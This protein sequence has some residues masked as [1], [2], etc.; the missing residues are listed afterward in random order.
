MNKILLVGGL[1]V[2]AANSH[3]IFVIDPTPGSLA[4]TENVLF[5]EVGLIATGSLVQGVLNDSRALVDFYG[6][7]E[8]L[9]TPPGGQARVTAVDGSFTML[10]TAMTDPGLGIA[11]YQ[12][13]VNAKTN[14]NLTIDLYVGNSIAA[15]G[16]FAISTSGSNWFRI[17]G[18]QG[19]V[20]TKVSM[21][22]TGQISDVRQNRIGAA[23]AP[24]PEPSAIV[25]LGIGL[26]MLL[27][28]RFKK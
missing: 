26:T 24:V 16:T 7:G 18:T 27:R 12:F 14:G 17:Y 11:A 19:E 6:A 15:T 1:A 9:T 2:A 8:N 10:T 22:S 21:T 20:M 3:A 13:D 5:N 23:P 4:G 25:G 28:R